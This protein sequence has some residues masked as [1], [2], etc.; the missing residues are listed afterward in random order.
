MKHPEILQKLSLEQ[1]CALLSGKN[2]WQTKDYLKQGVPAIWLSDGPNG[3]HQIGTELPDLR[4]T[5]IAAH[6]GVRHI[7]NVVQAGKSA[8]FV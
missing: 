4:V 7:E 6:P 5:G 1:K 2:T 3:L 8:G